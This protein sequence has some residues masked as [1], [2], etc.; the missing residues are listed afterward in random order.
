MKYGYYIKIDKSFNLT[1]A[2]DLLSCQK[3]SSDS[4]DFTKVYNIWKPTRERDYLMIHDNIFEPEYCTS[5][6]L[7]LTMGCYSNC[8]WKWKELNLNYQYLGEL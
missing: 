8:H 6:N 4:H 3:Y 2:L 1:A 5:S 7:K